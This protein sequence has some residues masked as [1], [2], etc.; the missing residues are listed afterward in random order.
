M[1]RGT[2]SSPEQVPYQPIVE[3]LRD[4]LPL[5]SAVDVVPIWLAAVAALVP[6][7]AM[8]RTDLPILPTI[9]A[10]RE[11][12]RLLEGLAAVIQGLSRQRPLLV[13]FEDLQW[14]G[15]AT[16]LAFE[17]LAR[18]VAACPALILATY[19]NEGGD[20]TR[21]VQQLRRKLQLENVAGHL[22]LGGLSSDAICDLARSLPTL[23][24]DAEAIG[25][26]VHA[27]CGGNPLFALELLRE[28]AESGAREA[29]SRFLQAMIE[30]RTSRVSQNARKI[31]EV[32]SVIGSTFDAD[33]L[34]EISG[35]P[36]DAVLDGVSELLG[37][38]LV[39]EVGRV[40]FA[41]TFSHQLI[42]SAIYDEIEPQRRAHWHRRVAVTIEQTLRRPGRNRRKSGV[43]LR[44]SRRKGESRGVL[45]RHGAAQLRYFRKPR[46]TCQRYP[47]AR[48][49]SR[50][51]TA[52]RIA[53][54]ARTNSGS[55]GRS[56]CTTGRHRR[57]R[58]S[59]SGRRCAHGCP[60]EAG[61]VGARAGRTHGR[62]SLLG[63]FCG[64]GARRERSRAR[65]C[66][67]PRYSA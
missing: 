44:Q 31:G 20:G 63:R 51:R 53:G 40:H 67:S 6:E 56:R 55:P 22:S 3:A 59:R 7:L 18:R 47:R 15:E 65:S 21:S 29:S 39:R 2:T 36:E 23:A 32:A 5:L 52:A 19:R 54:S 43:S 49:C 30:V 16:L 60:V 58:G 28:S 33:L 38:N 27:V 46:S 66:G 37:R 10:M 8:R 64:P 62:I 9:D 42:A 48:A 24:G 13:V 57:T 4:G 50:F 12:S 61:S 41:F 34:R 45:S 14:A 11:R 25:A 35:L 26:H 1:L 17:Y